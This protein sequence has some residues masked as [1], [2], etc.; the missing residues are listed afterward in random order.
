MKKFYTL[1]LAIALMCLPVMAHAAGYTFSLHDPKISVPTY[2]STQLESYDFSG[3]RLSI[4]AISNMLSGALT[5]QLHINDASVLSAAATVD[6][7]TITAMVEGMSKTI[8]IPTEEF[9]EMAN[10]P[11]FATL[12]QSY[13][14]SPF[15]NAQN[16]EEALKPYLDNI[17]IEETGET[18]MMTV[19]GGAQML[20][21]KTK[22]SITPEQFEKM[23]ALTQPTLQ[24]VD[25][26]YVYPIRS[27]LDADIW[28]DA[29]EQFA[30]V[31]MQTIEQIPISD[32]DFNNNVVDLTMDRYQS[33]AGAI[34]CTYSA[35]TSMTDG[36]NPI[37]DPMTFGGEIH[38]AP[39]ADI[40][41]F[42][43]VY[44]YMADAEST[45]NIEFHTT[46]K[47]VDENISFVGRLSV[48]ERSEGVV[49]PIGALSLKALVGEKTLQFSFDILATMP[50][51]GFM[52]P[53]FSMA[54]D[55]QSLED[56]AIIDGLFTLTNYSNPMQ[57]TFDLSIG[58]SFGSDDTIETPDLSAHLSVNPLTDDPAAVR[59]VTDEAQFIATGALFRLAGMPGM[60]NLLNSASFL[61]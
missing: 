49:E 46:A 5:A 14:D 61:Y 2:G 51:N 58:V 60:M 1:V 18:Q 10:I 20:M 4:N 40:E 8:T 45:G 47:R 31:T 34:A 29:S 56:S 27:S 16:M 37:G 3:L 41:G 35:V 53:L 26:N 38:L 6:L 50:S 9:L 52:A 42:Y 19:Y 17:T 57:P 33:D 23:Q 7:N 11:D 54:Y 21:T 25:V 55:G 12:M 36:A 59:Q 13:A 15:V 48:N 30:H 24:G 28:V 32:E 22:V 43:D 44:F 39:A